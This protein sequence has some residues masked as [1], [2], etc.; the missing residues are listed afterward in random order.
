MMICWS[1]ANG[2][3]ILVNGKVFQRYCRYGGVECRTLITDCLSGSRYEKNNNFPHKEAP[4]CGN[5]SQ[6]ST[7]IMYIGINGKKVVVSVLS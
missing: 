7:D 4:L 2:S 3:A 6:L 5:T 1:Y